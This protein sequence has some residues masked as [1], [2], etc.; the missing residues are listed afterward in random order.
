MRQG[1][2]LSPFLCKM[3]IEPLI[4]NIKQSLLCKGISI[5]GKPLEERIIV[6]VRDEFSVHETLALFDTYS[7]ASVTEIKIGETT[8]LVINGVFRK[9]FYL[10]TSR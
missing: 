1:C 9:G 8:A 5:A 2:G 6:L 7:K 10:L 4:C 3:A